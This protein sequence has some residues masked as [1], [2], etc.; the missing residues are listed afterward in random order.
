MATGIEQFAG[1]VDGFALLPPREQNEWIMYYLTEIAGAAA[2]TSTQIADARDELS[3]EPY[4][5]A[6]DLS[7]RSKKRKGVL[8]IFCKLSKG[9]KLHRA[10]VDKLASQ[11]SRGRSSSAQKITSILLKTLAKI[12]GHSREPYLAEAVGCFEH[13][14]Y[15]A[16][17]V[18][19]WATAYDTFRHWVFDGHLDKFNAISGTWKKAV[20][21]ID[22]DDFESLTERVVIDTAKQA[23][24][25]KKEAHKTLVALLD[26]RNSVAHPT[27][28]LVTP[29]S[30][31]AYLEEIIDEVLLK[32]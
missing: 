30:A 13:G 4:R 12:S 8:P 3:L 26:K 17:I 15:R 9:Y 22:I 25:V 1:G 29:A 32:Y 23:G 7:E 2:V 6:A 31:D 27:G 14:F 28:K 11:L 24:I 5:T 16:A 21:V 19:A 10:S 18:L 20:A